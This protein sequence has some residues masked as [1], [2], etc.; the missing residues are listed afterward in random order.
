MHGLI[1]DRCGATLLV[2]ADV[3]YQVKIEVY[4]AYD[5]L[6]ITPADL[7]RDLESEM[8]AALEAA[9]ALDPQTLENQ[10][11]K[12]FEFDLCPDCQKKFL[13]DPLGSN[14]PEDLPDGRN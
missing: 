1:C 11:Y 10:V 6:E 13:R 12:R 9:E 8:A 3:R 14:P 2:D 7:Q 5:P 4:A